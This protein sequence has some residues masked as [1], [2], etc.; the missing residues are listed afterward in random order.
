MC[1]GQHP[2]LV[3]HLR[4]GKNS[5]AVGASVQEQLPAGRLTQAHQPGRSMDSCNDHQNIR[6][7]PTYRADLVTARVATA[8]WDLLLPKSSH[9]HRARLCYVGLVCSAEV[10]P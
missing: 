4:T 9:Q 2:Y 1:K 6:N 3:V 8:L 10:L 7:M 5:E